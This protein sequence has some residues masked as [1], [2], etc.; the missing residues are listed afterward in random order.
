LQENFAKK[1]KDITKLA[2][3]LEHSSI[4]TTR[5][6]IIT[7]SDKHMCRMEKNETRYLIN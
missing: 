7:T 5:I 2:D 6:Y 3:I 4:N 1:E